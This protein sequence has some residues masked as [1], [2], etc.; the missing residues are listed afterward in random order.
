MSFIRSL[1]VLG[2]LSLLGGAVFLVLSLVFIPA[3]SGGGY[4]VLA[5]DE[6]AGDR[7][8]RGLL[9]QGLNASADRNVELPL[10]IIS[11]SSQWVFLDNFGGL[12]QV[13]LDEYSGR[14][15]SFDPRD[16]G[17]AQ[18]LR[19]FFIRA[20]GPGGAPHNMK[21]LF[22]IPLRPGA[23]GAGAGAFEKKLAGLLGN[24]S[25]SVE[26]LGLGRALLLFFVLM[27]AAAGS[28]LF[29]FRR[30]R[31]QI[32]CLPLLAALAFGGAPGIAM[33]AI[34]SGLAALLEE[35]GEALFMLLR[36]R[37][38]ASLFG[39]E[40][41]RSRLLGDVF[42]P[43]KTAWILAALL[44]AVYGAAAFFSEIPLLLSLG[45][46]AAHSALFLL[47]LR[48]RSL[49]GE[50]QDH[51]RFAPVPIMKQAAGIFGFSRLMLPFA[52]ASLLAA[53]LTPLMPG[54]GSSGI[55]SLGGDR[56]RVISEA[57]YRFHAEYQQSFSYRSLGSPGLGAYAEY[58][59]RDDGLIYPASGSSFSSTEAAD[60]PPFPLKDLMDFLASGS[61]PSS[62]RGAGAA[63]TAPFIGF[64]DLFPGLLLLFFIVPGF[65]RPRWGDKRGK[66]ILIYRSGNG[67][68]S[69]PEHYNYNTSAARRDA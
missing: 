68:R 17:Y 4:A 59:Q 51:I 29:F 14:V 30:F 66:K 56:G 38:E 36:Y 20:S 11:E 47:S 7:E 52:A 23:P 46:F 27:A 42:S 28:C 50:S 2:L 37:K 53:L 35:P 65:I 22:F 16:D 9:E 69:F 62:G 55:S 13:P 26:Y 31:I 63:G 6:A 61:S 19:D 5:F 57:E 32:P 64:G 39:N 8:I 25:F 34:L 48:A 40:R 67:N 15:S 41:F 49:Q 21:R 44:W 54:A 43:F 33:G 10:R 12:E 58:I 3:E 60:I 45:V 1:I 24:I 18:R